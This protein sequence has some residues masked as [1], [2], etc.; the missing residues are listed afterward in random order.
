MHPEG[1]VVYDDQIFTR[2]EI[3]EL[4]ECKNNLFKNFKIITFL[5]GLYS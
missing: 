3:P 2:D 4:Q 5:R 1:A